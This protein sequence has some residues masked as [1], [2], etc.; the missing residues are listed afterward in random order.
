MHKRLII[1]FDIIFVLL[2][3]GCSCSYDGSD[4]AQ[5]DTKISSDFVWIDNN[6]SENL[7]YNKHT[8]IVYWVGGS[9]M[10]NTWGD[11]YTTSY[12]TAYYAPNGLPYRYDVAN[13]KL[14]MIGE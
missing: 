9:Y 8:R 3:S 2:C 5:K 11:D 10:V 4:T 12:M 7:Y 6:A 14:V 13:K 1:I